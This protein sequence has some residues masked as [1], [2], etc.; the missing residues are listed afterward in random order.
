MSKNPSTPLRSSKLRYPCGWQLHVKPAAGTGERLGRIIQMPLSALQKRLNQALL[1][2]GVE[3]YLAVHIVR[4]QNPFAII[5]HLSFALKKGKVTAAFF[6]S[7]M[8]KN[9][10]I[11]Q[12]TREEY[13][14][15]L[16]LLKLDDLPELAWD[17]SRDRIER[18]VRKA[19]D[20]VRDR[21]AGQEG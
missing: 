11:A 14:N 12:A 21:E 4:S 2:V 10:T 8:M 16:G 13:E 1:N 19:G 20:S 15:T 3:E 7:S 6:V 18:L 5:E 9:W 17:R